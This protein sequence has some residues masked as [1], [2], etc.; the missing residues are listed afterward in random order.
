MRETDVLSFKYFGSSQWSV[1]TAKQYLK[2]LHHDSSDRSARPPKQGPDSTSP[3]DA[4][5]HP[6]Q[7]LRVIIG[8]V[9]EP[10]TPQRHSIDLMYNRSFRKDGRYRTFRHVFL[11]GNDWHTLQAF[12][13]GFTRKEE[14]PSTGHDTSNDTSH[15]QHFTRRVTLNTRRIGIYH[16][17]MLVG[18]P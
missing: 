4:L 17:K 1:L 18:V 11:A 7:V 13:R 5:H 3:V 16:P 15:A 9:L 12:L 2:R 14:R 6:L 8:D 10:F